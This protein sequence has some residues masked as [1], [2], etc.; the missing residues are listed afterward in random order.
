[1]T[2]TTAEEQLEALKSEAFGN[3]NIA[4]AFRHFQ[5]AIIRVPAPQP[6]V[7]APVR[8]STSGNGSIVVA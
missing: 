1:M 6:V 5:E 3:P 7:I 2:A 4:A 8:Y